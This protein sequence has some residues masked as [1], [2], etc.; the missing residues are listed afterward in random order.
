[1]QGTVALT[2][3]EELFA[4]LRESWNEM[5]KVSN[6]HVPDRRS[7]RTWKQL[8]VGVLLKRSTRLVALA[9][10]LLPWRKCQTVDA[11]GVSLGRFLAATRF[12]SRALSRAWLAVAGRRFLGQLER[13]RGLALLVV[14]GT[15][16]AKR[17]RVRR[18]GHMQYVGQVRDPRGKQKSV[19]GYVDLWAGVVLRGKQFLPLT[20]HLFSGQHPHLASQNGVEEAVTEEALRV[21][22]RWGL[23]ALVLADRNLGR[24]EW[25]I[26]LARREQAFIIRLDAD[27][28]VWRRRS[29]SPV[30]LAQALQTVPS[31]GRGHWDRGQEGVLA[32]QLRTLSARIRFSRSGRKHDYQEA[33]VHFV[34]FLPDDPTLAPLT[35][36]TRFPIR[37]L[38]RAQRIVDLYAQRWAIETAFETMS[39][40][41]LDRFMV[42]TWQ[43]IDR[44]LWI[45]ALAYL[46]MCLALHTMRRLRA[47]REQCWTILRRLAALGRAHTLGKLAEAIGLDHAY[48]LEA[49]IPL[50]L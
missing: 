2:Q 22:H 32:G 1:M 29:A 39:A 3:R 40:W 27:I 11:L 5:L 6:L 49:W 37:N 35:L 15:E 26:E 47:F 4:L 30:I 43:A 21:L 23:E 28:Q 36:V 38:Q 50:Q 19:P 25:V 44:L 16:Y 7:V 45:V 13:Y 8:I 31:L 41:G 12:P 46:L 48:H 18:S 20:R 17:S 42:R 14:D 9:Q 10:A 34:Q 33:P 24:K